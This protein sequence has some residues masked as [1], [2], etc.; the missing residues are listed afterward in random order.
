[1][2]FALV[3]TSKPHPHKHKQSRRIGHVLQLWRSIGRLNLGRG[4]GRGIGVLGL[5]KGVWVL[6]DWVLINWVLGV[7]VE[8]LKDMI[9]VWVLMNVVVVLVSCPC[10]RM[11]RDCGWNLGYCGQKG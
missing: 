11:V 9:G 2:L 5:R 3:S 6:G 10:P 8:V 1:M 7:V 4:E